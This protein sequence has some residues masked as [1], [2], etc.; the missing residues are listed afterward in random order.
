MLITRTSEN[1]AVSNGRE[2]LPV[3]REFPLHPLVGIGVVVFREDQVLLIRR[4][5]PPRAGEWSLPGGLQQLGE[6]VFEAAARE[7][8]EETGVLVRPTALVDVV[9]LIERDPVADR[10]RWHYTL[11]DVLAIWL[12]GEPCAADDATAA[13]WAD[14]REIACLGLWPET[15]RIIS[16]ARL[17]LGD[18]TAEAG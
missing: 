8:S 7:V 12:G 6:T 18:A 10:I 15:L 16:R 2:A 9:D 4:A 3:T 11:I 13:R 17:L 14:G 1:C 5:R